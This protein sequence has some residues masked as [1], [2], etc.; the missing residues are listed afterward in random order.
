M[1]EYTRGQESCE[2][3]LD[4]RNFLHVKVLLG[5]GSLHAT[6]LVLMSLEHLFEASDLAFA[7]GDLQLVVG[8]FP[9]LARH[10]VLL[11]LHRRP[12]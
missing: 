12:V 11:P 7:A 10:L 9:L 4:H 5:E 3:G 8:E 6:Q 2:V 1:V